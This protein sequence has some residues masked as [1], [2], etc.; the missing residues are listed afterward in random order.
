[1]TDVLGY[2]LKMANYLEIIL[3]CKDIFKLFTLDQFLLR[4]SRELVVKQTKHLTSQDV[5]PSISRTVR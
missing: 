5:F 2:I 4:L 1:M 3:N